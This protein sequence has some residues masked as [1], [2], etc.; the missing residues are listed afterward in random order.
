MPIVK[1]TKKELWKIIREKCLECCGLSHAMVEFCT[2]Q[3]CPNYRFR[4]GRPQKETDYVFQ[5]GDENV[6]LVDMREVHARR[7][8]VSNETRKTGGRG[9]VV[10]R[11]DDAQ[12]GRRRDGPPD[13]SRTKTACMSASATKEG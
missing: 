5:A 10:G 2:C 11:S 4:F 9:R 12:R 8:Q 6:E 13:R 1:V 7:L 3:R